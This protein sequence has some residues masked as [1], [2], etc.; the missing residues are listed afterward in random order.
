MEGHELVAAKAREVSYAA[1]Y[2]V[3]AYPAVY[4][5]LA[6][7][8]HRD[9]DDW[10]VSAATELVIEGFGRSGSTFAVLAF[11]QAQTRPVRTA[12]H[13]HAAAQIIS[14]TRLGVPTL[15]IV[16]DP[17][18]A[19]VAHMVR[20]GI[21]PVLPLKAWIRYH[22]RITPYREAFVAARLESV[23]SDFGAVVRGVNAKFGTSFEEFRHTP[24]NEAR[25]FETIERLN[26]RRFGGAATSERFR[27]LARPTPEREDRKRA[28][29]SKLESHR[30]AELR[31]RAWAVYHTLVPEPDPRAG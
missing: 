27:A 24:Q 23:G 17:D 15:V 2:I 1:R 14:A 6:R 20:R 30:L 7:I 26:H 12:H 13:S 21:P 4:M 9:C 25:V 18:S 29:R 8:R 28:V 11:E 31:A 22:E 19:V 3:N 16:R 10:T 5:P